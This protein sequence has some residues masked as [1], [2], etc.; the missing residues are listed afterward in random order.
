MPPFIQLFLTSLTFIGALYVVKLFSEWFT[1]PL[2]KMAGPPNRSWLLGNI[3]D[4]L[5]NTN[6]GIQAE[7][8]RKYGKTFKTKGFLSTPSLY[9]TD[10]N[11]LRHILH[12]D[13]DYQKPSLTRYRLS[14]LLGNGVLVT[15]GEQHKFQRRVMN[16]AFGPTQIRLLIDTFYNEALSLRDFWASRIS[17]SLS[18]SSPV[19]S[20]NVEAFDGLTRA[21]LD[22]I[23]LAGF[24]YKFNSLQSDSSQS[25]L[26]VAFSTIINS[27]GLWQPWKIL[28]AQIPALRVLPSFD[29]PAFLKAKETMARI[30]SDLLHE[31]QTL[32]V[33]S[34]GKTDAKDLLSL[35]VRSNMNSDLPENRRMS[36]EDVLAQ[37]PTF[38]VAGKYFFLVTT[39]GWALYA[40]SLHQD[41]QAKL[42]GELLE[43]ASNQP[44]MEELNAFPYLDKIVHEVLRLY[45]LVP[46]TIRV[47]MKD[48][49]VP[50]TEGYTDLEGKFHSNVFVRKGQPVMIPIYAV[51]RDT[52]VWGED[53][54][55]FKPERWDNL[56][57]AV[58]AIPGVWGHTLS[59]IGGNRACIGWRFSLIEMKVLLF[60][61]IRAF[62]FSL[63]VKEE[64]VMI[65]KLGP[66]L[67]PVVV[68]D[69]KERAK[70]PLFIREINSTSL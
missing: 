21:T 69:G 17:H 54:G 70:L 4:T 41:I 43:V 24:G 18:A 51:N 5:D 68:I 55:E 58:S 13:I 39:T 27:G 45:S 65:K 46:M 48:D 25:E 11:A 44:S 28:Q 6:G 20:G 59:F 16:A 3:A 9:T 32:Q 22:I 66:V 60:T 63:A 10:L 15:E 33:E 62:E 12:N 61:L 26:H 19:A 36:D 49:I 1:S 42:R 34:G 37:V 50:L 38:L 29:T 40:L 31:A 7:W 47:A 14:Q 67:K 8:A 30:G 52:S 53:A 57:E 56:P 35:L 2:R 23:G 64:E